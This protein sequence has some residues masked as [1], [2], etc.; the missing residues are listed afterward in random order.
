[1]FL[2]IIYK[3]CISKLHFRILLIVFSI[4]S[5]PSH[6]KMCEFKFCKNL[7]LYIIRIKFP[8]LN[9]N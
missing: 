2:Q 4:Y 8:H 5:I 3:T 9:N 7:V 6:S 1:M